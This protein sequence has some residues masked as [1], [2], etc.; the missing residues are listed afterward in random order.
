VAES[1]GST[2][3]AGIRHNYAWNSYWDITIPLSL[4][5]GQGTLV[6]GNATAYAP[7]I[8]TVVLAKFVAGTPATAAQR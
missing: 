1:G 6:L 3:R 5:T 4:T 2:V 8:D 7:N